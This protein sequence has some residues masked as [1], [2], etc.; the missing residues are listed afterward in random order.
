MAY[1]QAFDITEVHI[2]K[3]PNSHMALKRKFIGTS[4]SGDLTEAIQNAL[5]EARKSFEDD[6]AWVIKK[7]AQ[8][9]LTLGPIS[10]QIH[11]G[12]KGKGDQ[13]GI[14]PKKPA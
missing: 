8:N 6:T 12:P 14:G 11:V 10:V 2:A 13:G 1:A 5:E 9:Q 4:P 3:Q 7:I